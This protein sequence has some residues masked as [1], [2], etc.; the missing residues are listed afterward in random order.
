MAEFVYKAT[1]TSGEIVEGSMEGHDEKAVV[2][3]LHQ[4]GY[5][6]VRVMPAGE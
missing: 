3:S 4:L 6:P 1:K 2:R 5:I